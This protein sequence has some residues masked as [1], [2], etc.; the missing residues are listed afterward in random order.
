MKRTFI[1][2]Y[3]ALFLLFAL[4]KDRPSEPSEP[5]YTP[6]EPTPA[7]AVF[8]PVPVRTVTRVLI[9]GQVAELDT[10]EYLAGVVAAEMPASFDSE[11]LKAQAVAARTYALYC[12]G[13]HGDADVCSDPG[14]CQAWI[15][16]ED[17]A[18]KWGDDCEL[19]Y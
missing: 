17:M 18:S 1:F 16:R 10:G 8:T 12:S 6:S 2:A 13:K 19:Y 3:I 11:A 15:S 14:C 9:D 4:P 5:E 7:A